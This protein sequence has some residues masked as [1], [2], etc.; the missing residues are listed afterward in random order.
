M[1]IVIH[2]N[3]GAELDFAKRQNLGAKYAIG[4]WAEGRLSNGGTG[5]SLAFIKHGYWVSITAQTYASKPLSSMAPLVA[6][7]KHVATQF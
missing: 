3:N 2:A 5:A 7:A 6:L 1:V 4:E